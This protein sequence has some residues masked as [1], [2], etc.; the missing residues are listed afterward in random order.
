MLPNILQRVKDLGHKVFEGDNFDLNIIGE[1]CQLD[2]NAFD[3]VL[4][5]VYKVSGL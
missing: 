1:R 2:T 3:D 4:H 5:V